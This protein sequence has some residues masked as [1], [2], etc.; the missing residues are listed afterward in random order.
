MRLENK[1][2][3]TKKGFVISGAVLAFV[4]ISLV[5]AF[6]RSGS[7]K[8]PDP[9][10]MSKVSAMK[11]MA[12]K[13][14]ASLP[15]AEKQRY[16]EKIDSGPGKGGTPPAMDNMTENERNELRRNTRKLMHAHMK[17]RLEK[18]FSGSKEEQDKMLD[19]MIEERKEREANG[20][21]GPSPGG[22]PGKHMQDMLENTD[23]TTRAQMSA[24]HERLRARVQETANK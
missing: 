13:E 11:Y 14:F 23:S 19:E 2:T 7:A 8:A 17:K 6:F 21:G 5:V 10:V 18:F 12:T 15:D 1:K 3:E 9:E 4:V 24:M 22:D 16:F 20:A